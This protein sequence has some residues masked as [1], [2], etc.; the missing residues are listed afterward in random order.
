[1]HKADLIGLGVN[2]NL[3]TPPPASLRGTIVSL[4]QIAGRPL[5][6]MDVLIAILRQLHR[7]LT[8]RGEHPFG[9]ILRDYDRH[10][11]LV[12][13][14]VSVNGTPDEPVLSGTCTGLD[15]MGRLLVRTRTRLHLIIAGQVEMH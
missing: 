5:D 12:G 3:D 14:K 15:S 7:M 9:A 8:R 10:H 2:V 11:A 1:V 13:R 4:S 6:K